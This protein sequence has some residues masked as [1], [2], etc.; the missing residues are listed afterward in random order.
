MNSYDSRGWLNCGIPG[1]IVPTKFIASIARQKTTEDLKYPISDDK[2]GIYNNGKN[3]G[4]WVKV[5]LG[6][7]CEEKNWGSGCKEEY[8]DEYSGKSFYAMVVDSCN[9]NEA[10][11][12][13]DPNALSVSADALKQVGDGVVNPWNNR[14]VKW[15]FVDNPNSGP[16]QFY[17]GAGANIWWMPFYAVNLPR[18][19]SKIQRFFNGAWVDA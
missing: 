1:K 11:C 7:Q 3:C 16:V 4:R 17:F 18:G 5:T 15:E 12:G 2:V 14:E 8:K 6:N 10:F 13:T 9:A 19:I